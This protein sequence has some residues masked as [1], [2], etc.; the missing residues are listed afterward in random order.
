MRADE[1]E[2]REIN[3]L[4]RHVFTKYYARNG[5]AEGTQ[6]RYAAFLLG[7][8]GQ[9]QENAKMLRAQWECSRNAR[10]IVGIKW[11]LR[12]SKSIKSIR[13]VNKN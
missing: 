12:C 7:T 9:T 6:E 2:R 5:N 1:Y 13:N 11:T 10:R 3:N 4:C 8:H